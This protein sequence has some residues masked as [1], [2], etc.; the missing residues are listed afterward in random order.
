MHL[1]QLSSQSADQRFNSQSLPL[2]QL[3]NAGAL[4]VNSRTLSVNGQLRVNGG[5]VIAPSDQPA[6]PVAGQIYYD[7]GGNMLSYYNGAQF[8]DLPGNDQVVQSL[9]GATGTIT[10][11]SGLTL[12][13]G[14]LRANGIV[15]FTSASTTLAVSNDGN[16]NITL[17]DNR[18]PE[19]A[20]AVQ[21]AGGTIG[22]IPVFNGTQTIADSLLSQTNTNVD[23][24]G[25]LSVAD[26]IALQSTATATI[27]LTSATNGVTGQIYNDG[28]LHV[29]GGQNN[30]W[31][32][33][34]GSGTVFINA[35]NSDPVAI[36][37][38]TIPAYPLEVNGDINITSG[39]AYR[40][41]GTIICDIS[42][43][44]GAGGGSVT[45]LDGLSGALALANSTGSGTT[46]TIDDASTSAKGIAQFSS[47]N[48]SVSSGAV[49]TIQ[50]INAA[51]APIFGQLT[52]TS[53]QASAAML[54]VNNTNASAV[55][56]LID[57]QINGS[58]K[59]AVTP[60]GA[61]SLSSTINGQT[62]SSSASLTGSLAV[63]GVA[64]LNGGANVTGTLSAGTV[65]ANTLAPSG[66]LTVGGTVQSFTL[67]GNASS[68]LTATNSGNTT[69]FAFQSPTANVTYRLLT[70][71]AGT[72]DICTSVGNCAGAGSGVTT[73]GGTAGTIAKFTAGQ[74]IADSI[75]TDN[76]TTVTIGGAL[77]VNAITPSAALTVG[78]AGQNLTLQGAAVQLASTSAGVTNGLV[79][80]APSS[81]N[82]TITIPN[83]TGTICL[84]SGN[85]LGGGGGGANTSLSNLTSVAINTS[86]LPGVAAGINLGSG[87]LPIG[88]IYLAGSSGTPSV[89]NFRITGISTSGTRTL[90]LP[91]AG[92][93]V[94][95]QSS[96]SCGFIQN[97]TTTQ[98]A[99]FNVQSSS[100]LFPTAVV[101]GPAGSANPAM[102]IEQGSSQT[103]YLLQLQNAGATPL[104]NFDVS[105]GE[106]LAN[107][108][109]SG[110]VVAP[111]LSTANVTSGASASINLSSGST[112]ASGQNSGSVIIDSGSPG[113]G[114]TA[115]QINIGNTNSS[116]L[117][118]G[119]TG[120]SFTLRGNSGS[121]IAATNG[122]NTSTLSFA[123]P[124][125]AHAI[126][127]P[128]AGGTLC[129][130]SGNCGTITGTLQKAYGY[131]TG[132]TTPEIKLDNVR[133][134]I[135]IQDADTTLGGSQNF[136]SYRASNSLGLGSI[137]FG[138]GVQGNYF[139]K[140][141][142]D[143]VS[144]FQVQTSAGG[145]LF[146]VDST[147]GRVGVNLGGTVNPAY[148]LE[149]KGDLNVGTGVYRSDGTA[150]LTA[151]TC[152]GGQVMQNVVVSGGIV[153][154][155]TCTANVSTLQQAY[156]ASTNPEIVVN[157]TNGA[158]TVRD[159]STPI[160]ANLFE[161]QNNGGT[162]SYL[163]VT[164][165]SINAGEP[166]AVKPQSDGVAL[167]L[168]ST[169]DNNVFT[170]DTSN[171]RVGINLGGS[172]LPSL[173]NAGLEI[174]GALRLSGGSGS[175]YL[176]TYTTPN[177]SHIDTKIN[178]PNYDPGA[179]S[180]IIALGLPST[181]DTAS[182]VISLLDA[183]ASA[184]QPTLGIFSPNEGNLVGFSWEGSDATAYL[185][186]TGGN[187]ALRS[188][189]TDIMTLL[190][191]GNVG[192]GTSPSYKLDTAGDIN[193]STG[194]RI[195]GAAGASTTCSGGQF[196][197][198]Q[199]VSG[200]IVTGGSCAAA[201]VTLQ[202]AYTAS[203]GST[204]PEVKLDSTRGGLDIQDADS[205]IGS[206]ALLAVRSSNGSGLGTALFSVASAQIQ[207][208]ITATGGAA[209]FNLDLANNDTSG[210]VV[211]SKATLTTSP[212]GANSG[213]ILANGWIAQP[214][215]GGA[216]AYSGDYIAGFS[217]VNWQG[218]NVS[219]GRLIGLTG[220]IVTNTGAGAITAAIGILAGNT[221][222]TANVTSSYAIK[223]ADNN[224][225]DAPTNA[226]GVYIDNM[227]SG[228]NRYP[229]YVAG[230]TNPLL[231]VNS[232][233]QV[234]NRNSSDSTTAFQLQNSGGTP[235]FVADTTNSRL[236]VGNPTGDT[237]GTLLVLDT[238]TDSGDPAG[239]NGAMYYNSNSGKFRCY[240]NSEWRNCVSSAQSSGANGVG[241]GSSFDITSSTYVNLTGSGVSTSITKAAAGT[242]LT[243]M[244]NMS[245]F[246]IT[247][248]TDVLSVG[249]NVDSTDYDCGKLFYNNLNEHLQ[250]SCSLVI[251]GLTAGSKTVQI[252]VKRLS[253]TGAIRVNSDDWSSITVLETD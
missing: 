172:N 218:S 91:D 87:T 81:G 26:T 152:S 213:S 129:L 249:V 203:T 190:S 17:T 204:T 50:D 33:A 109:A 71:A 110:S 163:A 63:A 177:G 14:Q 40:I 4:F 232:T 47:T 102:V 94:C 74:T 162:I 9:G 166:L 244:V 7:Q 221:I 251:P 146:T 119:R 211:G 28:N 53:S 49:N 22:R 75:I 105:G 230:G 180:Q 86:L 237:T 83:I 243:V 133:Q 5:V 233:G 207:G 194:Y 57:L 108:V 173:A 11:G 44:T 196:L 167:T 176:D 89:N 245:G 59:F 179:S 118:I 101:I 19:G 200:G 127:L 2:A 42:G 209:G 90:T 195:G 23:V 51:A 212:A 178:V 219:S 12:N 131:S 158:L 138:W 229:L 225:T 145:N 224:G 114:G 79:F 82:K 241:P 239:V 41:D 15:S 168:K 141:T 8:I 231:T 170:V 223:V 169:F 117:L 29:T 222:N 107:L 184:H 123:A 193:S 21:S 156:D 6:S 61:L 10:L 183:R 54:T 3:N 150:G 226:Y 149:V 191:G 206:G 246:A 185:K 202:Q 69:T 205:T 55:G 121:T 103:G 198:N 60:A 161:V 174:K 45:S 111:V 80:A 66:A 106:S 139:Q 220:K 124:T 215:G 97:G 77:S 216:T 217:Q 73:P 37:E 93:T 253:G 201:S 171:S 20:S 234:V 186:T 31:L 151:T 189:T 32:E 116:S 16:G 199:V 214:A 76:G 27:N 140:P 154:G 115:G 144:V 142:S 136:A 250:A 56:N 104:V 92:G 227:T 13:A 137:V 1:G 85:C 130:D 164:A 52:L 153:T 175:G 36:N 148:A 181:A 34:G 160:G 157:S 67:Q 238:K 182:R 187:L 62:I 18:S 38:A 78:A 25:T 126:V 120:A 132:G 192:I 58:S 72:Y 122:A 197:Q 135:D 147:N 88:D 155:G 159:A 98:T 208:T 188:N 236:Y 99:S 252:R 228:T 210:F 48:F 113:S 134:S 64:N 35:G 240:E 43:C 242:K 128:D 65:T 100:T 68:T 248:V 70:T 24:S 84:D 30:L 46:I 235:L 39:H 143:S 247:S 165:S 112:T 95:L 96:A 125:T